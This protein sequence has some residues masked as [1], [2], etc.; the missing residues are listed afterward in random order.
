VPIANGTAQMSPEDIV[1]MYVK[2]G[3]LLFRQENIA[4]VPQNGRPIEDLIN[5]VDPSIVVYWNNIQSNIQ[6][7]RDITGLNEM[8]DGSSINPKVL[9]TPAEMANAATNNA[10]SGI[11]TS[12]EALLLS[13]AESIV[14]RLQSMVMAGDIYVHAIGK[15]T[16]E[17]LRLS[18]E[19]AL[20]DFGIALEK[21]PTDGERRNLIEEAKLT[22]PNKIGDAVMAL[23]DGLS[24]LRIWR[25]CKD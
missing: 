14:M 23:I 20:R 8:T 13:L 25:I 10:L 9:T 19:M 3:V 4:G 2:H 17:I 15:D 1:R 7:L 5:G 16:N 12:D 22:F 24:S 18:K 6:L 21:K 11:V